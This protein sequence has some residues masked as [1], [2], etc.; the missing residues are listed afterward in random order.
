MLKFYH[1]G[2]LEILESGDG[3]TKT[4]T[5]EKIPRILKIEH[6]FRYK[7]RCDGCG[8]GKTHNM[9][10]EDW[11]LLEAYRRWGPRY[12]DPDILWGKLHKRFYDMMTNKNFHFY[13]GTESQYGK[14]LI[15]GLYYPPK[16][17]KEPVTVDPQHSLLDF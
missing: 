11:E 10:C 2:K 4:L 17:G 6:K 12:N 9:S 3:Y 16:E 15:I 7:F 5:G 8:E 1:E 13:V 14:W